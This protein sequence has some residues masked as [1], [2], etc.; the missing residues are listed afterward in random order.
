MAAET[1]EETQ[2][3]SSRT[4]PSS[5]ARPFTERE[6]PGL[7]L[8]FSGVRPYMLPV[9]LRDGS[10][11]LGRDE[12]QRHRIRDDRVSRRHVIV[13]QAGDGAALRVRDLGS[14]NGVFLNGERLEPHA[15]SGAV[16]R[17]VLRIGR[18]LFLL[19]PNLLP[20]Q[21]ALDRPLVRDGIVAGPTLH[22]VHKQVAALARSGQGLCLRGESGCGKE[23]AARLFH[24]ASP[25]QGGPLV[26]VNCATI[27]KE[28]AERLL[29]GAVRGAYSGAVADAQGYL[30][31]A[32]GGTLFL[33]EV[34]ELDLS[35]QAKLLR[36]LEAREVV[37][38]G[39]T[40]G[41]SIQCGV[42]TATLR[43][44]REAVSAGAFR[45]DL[46][47]RIGR[48]EVYLPPLRERLEEIPYLI[49]QTIEQTPGLTASALLV[50]TCL[51]RP[52]PGNVRELRA[53]LQAAAALAAAEGSEVVQPK[54]LLTQA[55]QPLLPRPANP[56]SAT[57]PAARPAP[58]SGAP[59]PPDELLR[60]A[61]EKLGIA[62]RTLRKLLTGEELRRIQE[63]A[64]PQDRDVAAFM[65]SLRARLADA[66][67]TLLAAQNFN[68]SEVAAALETSRTTLI[69]LMGDLGL[70]RGTE[71]GAEQ[72][73]QTLARTGDDLEAAARLLRVS[74]Q[75]LKKRLA[76]LQAR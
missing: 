67:F 12:L 21:E 64:S 61:C 48:P 31:A 27:P 19:V 76:A 36:A 72:I 29:F 23:V 53:E 18:T 54:Y 3:P 51:L 8:C 63:D 5:T 11:E 7:V 25:H 73:Q 56:L 41:Q 62:P 14:T 26:A 69:K 20:Y 10:V 15:V 30:Q 50:E 68:Q 66:L 47:Y 46:Y 13:E 9:S 52:W 2:D 24:V 39:G 34:A 35:V 74:P 32:H 33:D 38:L 1:V 71:L 16:S 37:P 44:L 28:L 59:Q 75:A 58:P 57:P 17:G 49:A 22:A 70:P 60:K 65:T 55:G 45:G 43:D 4:P 6:S 40:R 42:C